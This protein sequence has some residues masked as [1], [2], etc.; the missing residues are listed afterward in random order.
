MTNF[1]RHFKREIAKYQGYN[2]IL[3]RRRLKSLQII[4]LT[5]RAFIYNSDKSGTSFLD[6]NWIIDDIEITT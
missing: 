2:A 5:F 4:K 6:R 3:I 1:Q